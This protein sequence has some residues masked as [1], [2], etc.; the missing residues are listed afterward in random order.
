V[1]STECYQGVPAGFTCFEQ[2]TWQEF[3]SA[4]IQ[5]VH[6]PGFCTTMTEL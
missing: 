3:E 1:I 5:V 2:A 6:N 4:L